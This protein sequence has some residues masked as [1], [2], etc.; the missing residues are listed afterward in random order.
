MKDEF[1]SALEAE[2]QCLQIHSF[3]PEYW[4]LFSENLHVNP[5]IVYD[6]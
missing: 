6:A 1:S 4:I 5:L 2:I 3:H